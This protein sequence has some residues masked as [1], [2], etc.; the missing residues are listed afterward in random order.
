[1]CGSSSDK[2]DR[3]FIEDV[4]KIKYKSS[5]VGTDGVVNIIASPVK[6]FK[7]DDIN[8]FHDPNSLAY[9]VHSAD[10]I[11]PTDDKTYS[12]CQYAG[13]DLSAG[14][15]HT[16]AYKTCVFGFPLEAVTTDKDRAK[17]IESVLLF[18]AKK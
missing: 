18:F 14:V 15:A 11:E 9:Y 2:V 17:L 8:Y 10:V 4:L 16:G 5:V 1:M 6:Q 12:I 3:A 7:K 13:S